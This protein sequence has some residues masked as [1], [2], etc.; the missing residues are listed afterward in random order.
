M[1]KL[2]LIVH[3]LGVALGL[4][5]PFANMIIARLIA[6]APDAERPVLGRAAFAMG[7][8]GG[9]ALPLLWITGLTLVFTKYA[10][11]A[12]LPVTFHAK[13]GAVVLLTLSVGVIHMHKRKAM[14]G[15]GAAL[16]RIRALGMFNL[17]CAIAAVA[18]AVFTFE[19]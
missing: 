16:S 14:Q 9:I 10:G 4:A 5:V 8:L 15:D 12:A 2:L 11:F 7:R 3:L 18:L 1:N 17:I 19:P 13:L 6:A